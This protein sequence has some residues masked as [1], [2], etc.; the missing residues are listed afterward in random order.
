MELIIFCHIT[1]FVG[2]FSCLPFLGELP[3]VLFI[4]KN[5]IAAWVNCFGR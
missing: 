2:Q 5:G 4:R 3:H 1:V